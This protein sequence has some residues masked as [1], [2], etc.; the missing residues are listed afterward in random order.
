MHIYS[1]PLQLFS[2]RDEMLLKYSKRAWNLFL[3]SF[4]IHLPVLLKQEAAPTLTTKS[5][6]LWNN[7]RFLKRMFYKHLL[8]EKSSFLFRYRRYWGLVGLGW[9]VCL[10]LSNASCFDLLTGFRIF[11]ILKFLCCR[12]KPFMKRDH[13]SV[14]FYLLSSQWAY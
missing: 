11:E 5:T 10:L 3:L 14:N 4:W 9:F 6:L 2:Y 7:S 13:N 1:H 8:Y 12:F